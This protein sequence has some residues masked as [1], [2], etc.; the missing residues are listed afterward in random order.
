ML[1]YCA[2]LF[3]PQEALATRDVM[4][5]NKRSCFYNHGWWSEKLFYCVS[6][7]TPQGG[8]ATELSV[9]STFIHHHSSVSTVCVSLCATVRPTCS[10]SSVKPTSDG[11]L[12]SKWPIVGGER[13]RVVPTIG[14]LLTGIGGLSM[15][16]IATASGSRWWVGLRQLV[17]DDWCVPKIAVIL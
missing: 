5:F 7:C 14:H 3:T 11:K 6:S 13:C 16:I 17:S 4:E 10:I 8:L 15:P 2:S 1:F 9:I 12:G